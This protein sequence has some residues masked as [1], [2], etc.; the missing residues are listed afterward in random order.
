LIAQQRAFVM[1]G[2]FPSKEA[3]TEAVDF[4]RHTTD[5]GWEVAD[6]SSSLRFA[7]LAGTISLCAWL[8]HRSE[9][10]L[11]PFGRRSRVVGI[12]LILIAAALLGAPWLATIETTRYHQSVLS[13]MASAFWATDGVQPNEEFAGLSAANLVQRYREIAGAPVPAAE[14]PHWGAAHGY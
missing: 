9:G 6:W 4:W 10:R 12:A 7:V 14:R 13:D 1:V 5:P 11:F 8:A 2:R 3:L